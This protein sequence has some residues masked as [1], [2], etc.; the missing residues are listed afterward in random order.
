MRNPF[1]LGGRFSL[2]R[3]GSASPIYCFVRNKTDGWT[4]VV[5]AQESWLSSKGISELGTRLLAAMQVEESKLEF[6]RWTK[7]S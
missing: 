2:E 6:V 1:I 4:D 3:G 5:L 7:M